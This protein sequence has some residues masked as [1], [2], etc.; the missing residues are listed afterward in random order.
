MIKLKTLLTE[1]K[2]DCYQAAGRLIINFMGD[3][4]ARLVHGMV[5]GQGS[6]KGL[7]FGHAWVEY[8]GKCLDHSN[9]KKQEIPKTVYYAVGNI[10]PQ[11]CKYYAPRETT[12]KM[13]KHKHWG[14]WDMSG[15]TVKLFQEDIPDVR[16]EI[17]RSRIRIPNDIL[18]KIGD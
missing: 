9:G 1:G 11:Q 13:M 17:G 10:M 12:R 7:K 14:P 15:A 6:L 18:D 2:G 4:S 3:K 8:G 16:G 5:E